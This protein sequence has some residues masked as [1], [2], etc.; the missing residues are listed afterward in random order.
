MNKKIRVLVVD[1]STFFRGRIIRA[2]EESGE[3]QVVGQAADGQEAISKNRLLKPDL[4]TMDVEM[5]VMDGIQAVRRI[6]AEQP[7]SIIMFSSLTSDG[8]Q[9]TLEALEAGA[10]DFLTKQIDAGFNASGGIGEMLRSRVLALASR[11]RIRTRPLTQA[12]ARPAMPAHAA[13]APHRSRSQL[14]PGSVKLLVLGASTGG[15]MA[16]QQVLTKLPKD[17]PV[18]VLVVVHMPGAFTPSFAERLDKMCALTVREA[19]SDTPLRRG[20]VLVAP[21]GLQTLVEG[22]P[23]NLRVKLHDAQDQLYKPSVDITLGSAARSIG[24]EVLAVVMTG[25]GADGREG[26]R[27]LKEKGATVWSQDEASCVVYGMPQA[28]EKAGLSDLVLPLNEIAPA[29]VR[30]L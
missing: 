8:A 6:M 26:A 12:G 9:A 2:L 27:L 28:I 3:I 23:Q 19:K 15:P 1:D 29:L 21:G 10:A 13:P 11:P 7:T 30:E 22:R 20:E 24:A 25:M 4:I 14:K 18:P 17:F 5:P 16:L